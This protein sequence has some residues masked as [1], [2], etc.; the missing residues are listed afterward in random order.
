[1]LDKNYIH[2][3][4]ID[5]GREAIRII[6]ERVLKELKESSV[7]RGELGCRECT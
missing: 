4:T 3:E 1:M 7:L 2:Y 6:S 5:A